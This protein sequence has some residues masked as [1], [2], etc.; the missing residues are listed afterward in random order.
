MY[1]CMEKVGIYRI[2]NKTTNRFYIGSSKKIDGRWADH[3]IRLRL[4]KHV[5]CFLQSDFDN[6]GES[7]FT[8]EILE[9]VDESKMLERET[10][11][12]N[13]LKPFWPIGYNI[14]EYAAGGDFKYHPKRNAIYQKYFT[15]NVGQSNPFHGKKH[16]VETLQKMKLAVKTRTTRKY[17]IQISNPEMDFVMNAYKTTHSVKGIVKLATNNGMCLGRCKVKRILQSH[18]SLIVPSVCG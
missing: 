13:E 3:F 4:G 16:S 7:D 14:L 10:D 17:T 11:Y 2:T 8:F 9:L 6:F 15:N 12:I 5:N 18:Q 1:L